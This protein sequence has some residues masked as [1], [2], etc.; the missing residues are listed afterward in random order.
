M[1]FR[2]LFVVARVSGQRALNRC[3][4]TRLTRLRRSRSQTHASL[5]TRLTLQVSLVPRLDL[6]GPPV[7]F[8][9]GAALHRLFSPKFSME[10]LRTNSRK[11]HI[12]SLLSSF[13]IDWLN[14]LTC[15]HIYYLSLQQYLHFL[16]PQ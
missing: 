2:K 12:F 8:R 13:S 14:N 16:C 4:G 5:G 11:N 6:A 1:K 3:L 10:M 15:K 9:E 7:S